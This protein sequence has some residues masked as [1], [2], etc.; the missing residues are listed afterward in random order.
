MLINQTRNDE[1][2]LA[3]S[4]VHPSEIQRVKPSKQVA[5]SRAGFTREEAIKLATELYRDYRD[6]ERNDFL[7]K[8]GTCRD[9]FYETIKWFG[10]DIK[11]YYRV[12]GG[13]IYRMKWT[14]PQEIMKRDPRTT[15]SITKYR[16][17][18]FTKEHKDT[19]ELF[20]ELA[21]VQYCHYYR[22]RK[23]FENVLRT[24]DVSISEYYRR[25][26]K[27][28]IKVEFFMSIDNGELFPCK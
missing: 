18:A 6:S 1:L 4:C 9:M 16:N 10:L 21:N 2:D 3:L 13:K 17:V 12:D 14:H 22:Q 7:R 28:N 19:R 27:Y 25:L 11:R 8:H 26:R 5:V 24:V 20:V 15:R 23:E